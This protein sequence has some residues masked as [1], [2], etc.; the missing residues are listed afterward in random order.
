[1]TA[2][3]GKGRR[4]K[5]R[6]ALTAV[7]AAVL[8]ASATTLEEDFLN[9]PRDAKPMVWWDWLGNNVSAE[10][11][12]KDM[13]A[14][15][16]AGVG[17]VTFFY[18]GAHTGME[19]L[20]N[21]FSP[22]V[23]FRNDKWWSLVRLA[24]E[25][26]GKNGLEFGLH[27]CPGWS[28]SGGPWITPERSMKEVV[29]SVAPKGTKPPQPAAK[30][31]FYRDIAEVEVGE[32]VYRFGYT[33]TG[34]RPKPAP[35]D[36]KEISLECDKLDAATVR[37]HMDN[38][39]KPLKEH[40]GDLVGTTVTH[41]LMDSYE[42][43]PCNWTDSMREE[44]A[45][46]R[47]YDPVPFL[48]VLAGEKMKGDAKF[49]SDLAR[50]VREL[51]SECHY[52]VIRDACHAY[53][54]TFN[55]EPYSGPF[56]SFEA[57]AICDVPMVEFWSAR[58]HWMGEN[59]IGVGSGYAGA[60]GRAYGKR[61]IGAESF[62]GMPNC[63]AFCTSPRDLKKFG[64]KTLVNGI[65]RLSFHHWVHQ[66]FPDRFKPGMTFGW[67]GTQFG[68][69]Q[70][71]YPYIRDFTAYLARIQAML[72]RGEAVVDT[73]AIAQ[74]PVGCEFDA[75]PKSAEATLKKDGDAWVLPS[76]RRYS[77]LIRK[78]EPFVSP[79]PAGFSVQH[80]REGDV[81]WY[82]VVNSGEAAAD[83]ELAFDVAGF[84]PEAWS[85]DDGSRR[86]VR[87]WRIADG[88]TV[89]VDDFAAVDSRFYVFRKKTSAT[90]SRPEAKLSAFATLE[91]GGAWGVTFPAD[92]GIASGEHVLTSL[93]PL[94]DVPNDPIRYFSGTATYRKMTLG[95]FGGKG[96]LE[97]AQ[98]VML[99]LGTVRE[100]AEVIVNGRN[101][102]AKWH[103]P[104]VWDVTGAL[105]RGENE[106]QV[107]VTN[108]WNNRMIG[109]H[110]EPEDC[111]WNKPQDW[112]RYEFVPNQYAG[113]GIRLIPDFVINDTPRPSG[114]RRTFCVWDFFGIDSELADSGLIGPVRLEFL[115]NKPENGR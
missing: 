55:L 66:P 9:P 75:I 69:H 114:N 2:D 103:P 72:Q 92:S 82:F 58:T 23:K 34:R 18:A 81:H 7:L 105:Q 98:R 40:L 62:T 108:N 80:R 106:I 33:S 96:E 53:G 99:D 86:E 101:L 65:N 51:F 3:E 76:G 56:D 89:I 22:E 87:N 6:T 88:K 20:D 4:M 19:R 61:I 83:A 42:A 110:Q 107:K 68:R 115:S 31:G 50:T 8:S 113:R 29:W 15:A 24:A 79:Y 12:V 63:S 35:D 109:D 14:I 17:G 32:K 94:K 13:K 41:I 91:L 52:T 21:E 30:L 36:I 57:A 77:R 71:W 45:K 43:G 97:Q 102:G 59:D 90:A 27:N 1:M 5:V 11:I 37:L 64:D 70:T 78:K 10:G 16:D 47:G 39:L 111:V 26:A 104:F 38:V 73:L 25:E 48:P 112:H 85:P 49:K 100:I 60:V 74:T 54:L 67:W 84:V 28:V 46:R 95:S 93:K 44:F